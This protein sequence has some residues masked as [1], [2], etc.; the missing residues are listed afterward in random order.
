MKEYNELTLEEIQNLKQ[1]GVLN[2]FWPSNSPFFHWLLKKLSPALNEAS[3]DLHDYN[4]NKGGTEKDREKADNGFYF[5]MNRDLQNTFW[6]SHTYYIILSITFFIAV[7]IG[8]SKY[9]NYH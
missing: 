2:G 6:F 4:Y 3:A 1:Q 7:R 5:Y 8:W 9:F